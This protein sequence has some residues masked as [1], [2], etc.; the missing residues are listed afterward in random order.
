MPIYE[1]RCGGC[2]KKF[3]F[4]VGVS[5]DA[6]DPACPNCDGKNLTRLISKVY[7]RR[8]EEDILESMADPSKI[9]DIEDPKNL[10][11][12][13]RR[14]GREYGEELGDD[15]DEELD[16]LEEEEFSRKEDERSDEE[17]S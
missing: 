13:A 16:R 6:K 3:S 9:G 11:K 7:I 15:F 17:L 1:Y 5:A 2:N 8:S 12:W 10:K 4:L 14:L